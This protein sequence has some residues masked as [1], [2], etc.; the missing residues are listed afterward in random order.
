MTEMKIALSIEEAA[1]YTGICNLR[2]PP[3]GDALTSGRS[4]L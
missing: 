1:D 4:A 2:R 3:V